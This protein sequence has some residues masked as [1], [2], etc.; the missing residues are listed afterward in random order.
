VSATPPA[1]DVAPALARVRDR[2]AAAGGDPD[3][4]TV[5]AVTKGFGAEAVRAAVAAGLV[6]VGEN[7]A[8]ELSAKASEVADPGVRWH[9]IGRLQTNKV[10]ALAGLVALWQ[11]ID[12]VSLADELAKRA[13]GARVLIQVAVSGEP[14]KGGCAPADLGRL[15]RRLRDGGLEVGGLMAVGATGPPEAARAG[16]R[17]LSA[18]ADRLHLPVRSMGMSHDLEV[19]VQEGS[20]MVRIGEALFGPRPGPETTRR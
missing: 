16:F 2:I 15:V 6:D 7:Y 4:V 5:V 14:Q 13:P 9:F 11:T 8:Q 17:R 18:A 12:R 1:G 10:R 19:A 20:T 3:A